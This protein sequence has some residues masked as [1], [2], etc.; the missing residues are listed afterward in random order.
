MG[1]Q[2]V[3]YLNKAVA[4]SSLAAGASIIVNTKIDS[5][6]EQGLTLKKMMMPMPS[7][8]GK[9]AGEGPL[10]YGI[11]WDLTATL[12]AEAINA[13]PQDEDDTTEIEESAR[14]LIVLGTIPAGGVADVN[15]SRY[16]RVGIPWKEVPEGTTLK[17]FV[18]NADSSVLTTGTVVKFNAVVI[19]H[20][21]DD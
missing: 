8:A 20:W 4:L 16:E 19:G 18:H 12:I 2:I 9:T 11:A 3:S 10:I 6:R 7:W 17:F 1:K 15:P 13:D 21:R 5:S 14:K